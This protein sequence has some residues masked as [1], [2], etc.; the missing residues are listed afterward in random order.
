[1]TLICSKCKAENSERRKFCRE[2]GA[3]I[4]NF[5]RKCGFHNSFADKYCGGCGS[6]MSSKLPGALSPSEVARENTP[7]AAGILTSAKYTAEDIKELIDSQPDKKEKKIR[8]KET[9]E[10]GELSQDALD[11]MFEKGND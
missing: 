9:T 5:C 7:S 1:M 10:T 6:S 11:R 4:A 3:L 2:C 8:K